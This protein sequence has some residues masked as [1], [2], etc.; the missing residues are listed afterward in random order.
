MADSPRFTQIPIKMNTLPSIPNA[1]WPLTA[2]KSRTKARRHA[3]LPPSRSSR[4]GKFFYVK[5][6]VIFKVWVWP[7]NG[8]RVL[9]SEYTPLSGDQYEKRVAQGHALHQTDRL[10][11][12]YNISRDGRLRPLPVRLVALGSWKVDFVVL[13]RTE[14]KHPSICLSHKAL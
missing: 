9:G 10:D 7:Q 5:I 14:T 13:C 12:L 11:G 3:R 2:D 8:V 6:K 1:E 4:K